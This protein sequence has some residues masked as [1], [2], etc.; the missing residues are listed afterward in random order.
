VAWPE[1]G[2]AR[3]AG[4][5]SFGISGTNAHAIIEQAPDLPESGAEGTSDGETA[6]S[7][8]APALLP[9]VPWA[10]SAKSAAALQ[11]QA[12][13]LLD[14]ARRHPEVT[15][16]HTGL[17]LGTARTAFDHRAVVLARDRA[18]AV[19]ELEEYVAGRAARVVAGRAPRGG[20][21]ALVFPGQG[22]QWAGMAAELLESSPVFA[23]RMDECAEAL[24]P[25]TDWSLP[26]VLRR[27]EADG[28]LDRVDVVQPAL[29]AVMVSLA[30]L[31]RSYGVVPAAVVGHSQGEIAAACVAGGLSLADAARVVALRSRALRA[32][33]GRGGMASVGLPEAEVQERLAV[34]GGRLSVAAA[35]GPASVVV[36]GDAHALGELLARCERDGVRARRVPVDYASHSAQVEAIEEV[37]LRD[38][39]G[40]APRSSAVPFY[41]TVTG[42]VLD[43]A[44]LDAAYWYRNL[45]RTVRFDETVRGLL[46]DGFQLFVEAGAHPVLTMGIE[47]TAED[48]GTR[49]AVVGSLR[50]GEGGPARFLTSVA[51]AY[52]GGADVDWRAVFAGTGAHRVDLPTYAFQRRRYW[53]GSEGRGAGDLSSAGLA[54]AGHPLLGA[55]VPLPDS[56]GFLLTGRL[57]LRTHTWLADHA[58]LGRAVLPGTA[59]VELA[60][61]AGDAVGCGRIEELTL[62]KPLVLPED[63]AV[64]VQL[65]VGGPG[66]AGHRELA[67]YA[68]RA[69]APGESWTRHARGALSAAGRAA[70][71]ADP[72]VWPPAGAQAVETAGLHDRLA[73]DGLVYGPAFRGLRAVWRLG[74]E[75]F[76]DV[77]LPEELRSE[78]DRFGV[79]PA[80]LDAAL[81]AWPAQQDT[82]PGTATRGV[83][84]PFAWSGVSLH[85]AGACAVRARLTPADNGV[86]VTLYDAA[87]TPVV[88]ADALV[89]RPVG[90]GELAACEEQDESLY[91]LEWE[92]APPPPGPE[93][94][95]PVCAVVGEDSL[96]VAGAL[97]APRYADF[98]ALGERVPDVVV[99]VCAGS[100]GGRG[101]VPG[102]SAAL[103]RLLRVAQGWVAEER[104]AQSRLVVVTR[105]AVAVE[106]GEDVRDLAAAPV[107]GLV[108]SA[109]SEHP[110]RFLLLDMDGAALSPD[111]LRDALAAGEPQLALRGG[112]A[113][114][115][116]LARGPAEGVLAPPD[117]GRPWRIEPSRERTIE[118]LSLATADDAARALGECEVRVA[119]RAA[120]VNFRDVLVSLGTYPDDRALMGSEGAGVVVETGPGAGSFAVGDRVMGLWTGGFGPLVVADHRTLTRIP[121]GWS[122]TEAASVPVAFVTALYALRELARVRQ[123]ES[124]LVH[125]AAGGV[126]MAAVQLARVFGL[127]V[128][129]T[130][131]PGK[132][133]ALRAL[134]VDDARLASSRTLEFEQRFRAAS[135]KRGVDVVLDS[136]TGEHVDASLRLLGEGG[137]FIEM[138]KADVRPADEVAAAHPGVAYRAFDLADAGPERIGEMLTEIVDLFQRGA[139]TRLPTR[140]WDV[141]RAGEAFRFMSRARHVGKLVL[142]VPAALDPEGVVLVTGAGGVLGGLAA[143]HLVAEHGVRHLLLVGRRGPAGEGMRELVAELTGAGA[144][145]TVAACDVADRGALA[146]VLS[147]LPAGRGVTGVVHAA[148]VLDDGTVAALTP[149]RVDAVLRAK[150]AGA[151]N[152]HVLTRRHDVALFA[153]FSSAAGVLGSAG[154]ANYAAANT[155]L[156]GLAAH[157]RATGLAGVSLAW[158]LWAERSGMT[159][160]L[161]EAD[162]SRMARV[163]VVPFPSDEGV[164]LLDAAHTLAEGLV[165]PARLDTDAPA[166]S[167]TEVP[168]V[169]K[170]LVRRTRPARRAAA[171][172][173]A[174]QPAGKAA[175]LRRRLLGMSHADREDT[176]L[177]LVTAQVGAVLGHAAPDA[178]VSDRAFKD[179]GL[180]SLTA[181]ELRNLLSA[182]TGLRLPATL[183]FDH[184]NSGALSAHLLAE[185][186]RGADPGNVPAP[187]AVAP[188]AGGGGGASDD[189]PVA[190]V[191]MGCRYPG[192]VTTPE[193]LWQLVLS[194]GDAIGPLPTDRGWDLDGIYDPDPDAP[195]KTYAREGGF[196]HTAGEFDAEFFGISP[197]EALAMDPQQRLL[198]E[199]SWEALERA[200]LV[201]SSLRGS[202]TGVFVG[203]HYQEYGPRLH[204]AAEGAEGHLMTG[205]AASVLSGRVAYT[206]GLEGPAVTVDTACSS[207]L[208]A[209]HL[210]VRSLRQGECDL[211]LAGGVAVMPN[212]GPLMGFSR[213]RGL[214]PDGRCRAFA[215]AADGTSLAEG[216]GVLVV[217][218]LSDARRL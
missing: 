98:D 128:F 126:G 205:T 6:P 93:A 118:G 204:E 22:A 122:F 214:A 190:I 141:R 2:R 102:A 45:R 29:W 60:L 48:H 161:R 38:L 199:T 197:R 65:A 19:R 31:W 104:F 174:S 124:L 24:A 57:S 11:G 210:A 155:F 52:A 77:A 101:V 47:Q 92:P 164:R 116:R 95:R 59:F 55:A 136:T 208:V 21:A 119:V 180:D 169:L 125:S 146:D 186:V 218:R 162:L 201:A 165:V 149:E 147:R 54:P 148:G 193:E 177:G 72:G 8:A 67:V 1:T 97:G 181:V 12:A 18:G 34:W 50:R 129:A 152:L 184:P 166:A 167:G 202:R 89:T 20:A 25:Y 63:G 200:G 84:L 191:G 123:G 58:V 36:S 168:A 206:L 154:Q 87:G 107:W 112:A 35:N 43:T 80:L 3:R 140:V 110:E 86:S 175:E 106:A 105:G 32:L 64:Q 75:I 90:E 76:A 62:E 179:L 42:G 94:G 83:R 7:S 192:G 172:A 30:E 73:G 51:E 111:V 160:H 171:R 14:H 49:A 133:D 127:R 151:W 16:V 78:A 96:G 56:G 4:V 61:C 33:S 143:R 144:S 156:D 189:G 88:S 183:A 109:Q 145:V 46:D 215:A 37:L 188:P 100:A 39:A 130:A 203:S 121:D 194:G 139:L 69:D 176:V 135:G 13:K 44:E 15:A 17:A 134:G 211:A 108:R 150:A 117:G 53:L 10:F 153:L 81:H 68:R 99:V 187:G 182:A 82:D 209:L 137:R 158:G 115:P 91:R 138:G 213:Q 74:G 207:S 66:E 131:G 26:D 103:D 27:A 198:L 41:S 170:G 132:W 212:P 159:E 113:L 195:G 70:A 23:A 85:A 142:S 5:S 9:L 217:E 173:S 114:V 163:G 185:L 216:V 157:R 71:P 79:H 120:G 196:L 28:P 178:V 40:I